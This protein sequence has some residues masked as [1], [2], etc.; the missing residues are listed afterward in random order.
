MLK[1][2]ML[3]LTGLKIGKECS[4]QGCNNIRVHTGKYE[5]NFRTFQGLLKAS[6]TVFIDLKLMT[7]TTRSVKIL[8]KC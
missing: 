3:L 8:Q 6:P 5:Y 7:N 2:G 1:T 4:T